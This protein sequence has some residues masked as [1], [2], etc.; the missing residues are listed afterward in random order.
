MSRTNSTVEVGSQTNLSSSADIAAFRGVIDAVP[1]PIFVKDDATRFLVVNQMMCDFMNRTYDE[2]IGK[3]DHDFIPKEQADVFRGNDFRVLS[4][5]EVNENE[6]LFDAGGGDIRTIVTRKKRLVMPDGKRLLVGSITDISD[7][8]RAEALIRHLAEHDALTGLPNRRRFAEKTK[9][10]TVR[11]GNSTTTYSILLIDLDR[12]K[13]VNDVYGHTAG[14][15]VLCEIATRI[16]GLVRMG[17]TI[18]RLGGDEFAVI[19][20]I[21]PALETSEEATALLASRIITK[22]QV[23]IDV[24]GTKVELG[25]SIGIAQCPAD[26][27]DPNTLLQLADIA[28][29]A[30]KRSGRGKYRFFDESLGAAVRD[31]ANLEGDLRR[32][33]AER[34]IL[35]YYQPLMDLS[36][37]SLVGFEILAQWQHAERGSVPPEIFIPLAEKLGLISQLSFHLL[38]TACLD[39]KRWPDQ[40]VLALNLSPAQLTDNMLP[41]QVLGV[42]SESGFPPSRLEIEITEGALV[43]DLQV[44][45]S[46]L[47]SFQNLGMKISLDNFGGG[48]SNMYRL[49]E[50][51]F[52]K[53]KI[54]RSF[55]QSLRGN[56]ESVTIV[57]AILDLSKR[58]GL[59]AIAHRVGDADAVMRLIEGGGEF[60]QGHAFGKAVSASEA[61]EII[62]RSTGAM[63]DVYAI[64]A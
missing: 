57:N 38:R 29:Y 41:M 62:A 53:V 37:G 43:K 19:C 31:Q 33:V 47:T 23:P 54:D 17:D 18:A 22:I 5:G 40:L 11:L 44:A 51:R 32:A 36:R 13:P 28:M 21:D 49:P 2:L 8:R 27:T 35:P 3:V 34:Q 4:T 25:A 7:F 64:V 46:I 55:I 15:A 58:L 1:H 45:K 50:L 59:P 39:A 42:L 56:P 30:A 52:D 9:D 6:E 60:G 61:A 14:D 26:G 12:F 20:A 24:G 48:Y 16:Q 10:A 63:D